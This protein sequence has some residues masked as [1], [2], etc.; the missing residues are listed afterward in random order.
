MANG[1][2][3]VKKTGAGKPA[4]RIT[5]QNH[6]RRNRR[7]RQT[8]HFKADHQQPVFEAANRRFGQLFF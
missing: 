2:K 8:Q 3:L 7:Y 6:H 4:R 1:N 5:Q